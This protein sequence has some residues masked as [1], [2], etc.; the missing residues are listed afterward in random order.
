MEPLYIW[1]SLTKNL[2]KAREIPQMGVYII[3]S[4]EHSYI[5]SSI[6]LPKRLTDHI[7][8]IFHRG[9]NGCAMM[10]RY[11]KENQSLSIY[12]IQEVF[13]ANILRSLEEKCISLMHPDCNV[14]TTRASYTKM[15]ISVPVDFAD[16]L[17]YLKIYGR[18]LFDGIP[19]LSRGQILSIALDEFI[20][21]HESDLSRFFEY[22]KKK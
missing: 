3:M 18:E 1:D 21:N 20:E 12:L 5:G 8:T 22:Y 2:V 15:T 13:D 19:N 14:L 6:D 10:R 11:F 16:K 9:V 4:G 17:D 7:N